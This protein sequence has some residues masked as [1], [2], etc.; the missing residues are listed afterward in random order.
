MEEDLY[1]EFGNYIGPEIKGN[2]EDSDSDDDQRKP[3]HH[4]GTSSDEESNTGPQVVSKSKFNH[5]GSLEQ[6]RE[7]Q[8]EDSIDDDDSY[9][10]GYQVILREDE[11]YYP[12]AEKIYG[13]DVETLIMDEDAQ[14]LT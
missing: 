9:K 8:K 3:L 6:V 13:A 1:D 10:G 11:Q 4:L 7:A 5:Y 2:D 14:P 12:D